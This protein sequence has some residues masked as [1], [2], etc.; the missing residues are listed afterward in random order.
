MKKRDREKAHVPVPK[1]TPA[2]FCAGCGAV[3]LDPDSIC[4]VQGKGTKADW[5]G[6]KDPSPP[7]HCKN[8]V[9]NLRWVCGNCGKVS[10]NPEL[11]CEP[12]EFSPEA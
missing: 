8:R 6:T 10:V 4:K 12:Q 9:N 5:C 11:L 1:E 2:F 7:R 3:S